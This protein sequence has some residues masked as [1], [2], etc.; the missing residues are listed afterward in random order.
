[1]LGYL[2]RYVLNGLDLAQ[3]SEIIVFTDRLPIQRKRKAVE[4]AVKLTL[5]HMLPKQVRYRIFH[6]DSKSNFDLQIADYCNWAICRKWDRADTRSYDRICSVVKSEF[7]IFQS[8]K[9]VYY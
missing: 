9:N 6:H 2:L 5:A 7:N 3:Y 4:K 1:M 8:G